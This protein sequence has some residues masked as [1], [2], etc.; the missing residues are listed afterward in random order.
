MKLDRR[1]QQRQKGLK[2]T[3]Q[4][5]RTTMDRAFWWFNDSQTQHLKE[6]DDLLVK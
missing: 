5:N 2:E 4:R 1:P 3:D 6:E